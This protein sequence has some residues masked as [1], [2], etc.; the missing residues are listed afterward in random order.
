MA[1]Y[2]PFTHSSNG[3]IYQVQVVSEEAAVKTVAIRPGGLVLWHSMDK[4]FY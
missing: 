3:A 1:L 4:S 2:G